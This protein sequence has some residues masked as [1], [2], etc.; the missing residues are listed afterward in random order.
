M[1][2]SS[3]DPRQPLP[4]RGPDAIDVRVFEADAARDETR[5]GE[6]LKC[7]GEA[8]IPAE[9]GQV[10]SHVRPAVNLCITK[11]SRIL[12]LPLELASGLQRCDVTGFAR[13]G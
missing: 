8:R 6:L 11:L 1:P 13:R 12:P 4:L 2:E 3:R 7:P 5:Y 9:G 10:R